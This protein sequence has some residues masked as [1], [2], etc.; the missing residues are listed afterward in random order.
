MVSDSKWCEEKFSKERQQVLRQWQTGHEVLLDEAVAFHKSL[1]EK[2]NLQNYLT[3]NSSRTLIQPRGGRALLGQQLKLLEYL[4]D[5]GE[6]DLLTITVDGLT[7]QQRFQAAAE[8][9]EKCRV[10]GK[11]TLAGFPVVN[12]GVDGCRQV[13]NATVKPVQLRH[14]AVDA[15]LLAEVAVAGGCTSVEGGG[16]STNIPY[17]RDYDLQVSLQHWQYVDYLL[18][19]YMQEG[20]IIN[21]EPFGAMTGTLV[22][23]CISHAICILETLLASQQGVGSVTLSYGQCG[24][25]IQDV[26]AIHTLPVLAKKYLERLGAGNVTLSTAFHQWM[27]GFPQDEHRAYGLIGWAAATAALAGANK[28]LVKTPHEALGHPGKETIAAGLK[29]TLQVIK[30]VSQQPLPDNRV[31]DRE[32]EI[33]SRETEAILDKVLQLG[34]GDV[35]AGILHSFREGILDVPFAPSKYNSGRV[36][37]ARDL[38]GAVRFLDTGGLPFDADI[39]EFHKDQITL[40]GENEGRQPSFQMVINDIHAISKGMLLGKL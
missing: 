38:D 19:K 25:L 39:R 29:T 3:S 37:P 22:P 26:A 10:T 9:L 13:V 27:G 30:M 1:P 20:V 34:D 21:R 31:L 17:L 18:G 32:K 15:R 14:A 36:L 8:E 11:E 23:P 5:E 24:N 7:R 40:R 35:A 16:I 4:V 33:I 2:Q 6:A 28:V 12:H